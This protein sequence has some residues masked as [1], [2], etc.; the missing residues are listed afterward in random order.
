M[1]YSNTNYQ[2]TNELFKINENIHFTV[3]TT[4]IEG[5]RI[6]KLKTLKINYYG[7]LFEMT[8]GTVIYDYV[9]KHGIRSI[10]SIELINYLNNNLNHDNLYEIYNENQLDNSINLEDLEIDFSDNLEINKSCSATRC[11]SG[12][13]SEDKSINFDDLSIDL[14]E[15]DFEDLPKTNSKN[16]KSCSATHSE[17]GG[18]AAPPPLGDSSELKNLILHK[19]DYDLNRYKPNLISD[20]KFIKTELEKYRNSKYPIC[21]KSFNEIKTIP[22]YCYVHPS[23][24]INQ[25]ETIILCHLGYILEKLASYKSMPEFNTQAM[26]SFLNITI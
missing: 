9:I 20:N 12:D 6:C 21:Y 22:V 24:A 17:N 8:R 25:K 14:L 4:V 18:A 1:N 7:K 26:I 5:N 11:K 13:H 10:S 2:F 23:L 3:D 19:N 16:N 15:L